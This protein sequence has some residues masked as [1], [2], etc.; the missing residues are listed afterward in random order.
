MKSSARGAIGRA[1]GR[2]PGILEHQAVARPLHELAGE[3]LGAVVDRRGHAVCTDI[4]GAIGDVRAG[5]AM[6]GTVDREGGVAAAGSLR[7]LPAAST[8]SSHV[9]FSPGSATPACSNS[10]LLAKPPVSVSCVMKPGMALEPSGRIQSSVIA[11]IVVPVVRVWQQGRRSSQ[12][13]ASFLDVGHAGDVRALA[14]FE[15]NGKLL[16][17]DLVG[18]IVEGDVDAGIVLHEAIEQVLE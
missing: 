5:Y 2:H 9:A 15:L 14:G 8:H 18:D 11:E 3:G 7:P 4:V 1:G 16:L 10:V 6:A 12:W 13:S 17:D